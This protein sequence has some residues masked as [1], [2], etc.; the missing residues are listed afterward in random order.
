MSSA[1]GRV[2]GLLHGNILGFC[3]PGG[4]S[5]VVVYGAKSFEHRIGACFSLGI[6]RF[7]DGRSGPG[8]GFSVPLLVGHGRFSFPYPFS[9]CR[10]LVSSHTY[11]F[12]HVHD[13]VRAGERLASSNRVELAKYSRFLS[14]AFWFFSLL[15]ALGS[16]TWA[17]RASSSGRPGFC[18]IHC[19]SAST[20]RISWS[21]GPLVPVPCRRLAARFFLLRAFGTRSSCSFPAAAAL[22]TTRTRDFLSART[23]KCEHISD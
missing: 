13:E 5:G 19:S 10:W 23:W 18:S 12:L 3:S 21:E 1:A 16:T 7:W 15:D 11:F 4:G 20:R 6:P 2:C 8:L 14:G 9:L 17:T 22:E